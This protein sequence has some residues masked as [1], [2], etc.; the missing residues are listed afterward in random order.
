MRGVDRTL[1]IK[2]LN[3]GILV[4]QIY[5]DDIVFGSISSYHVQEFV[6]QMKNDFEMSM[7][8][9]LTYFLGL[10][11][12]QMENRIFV[13]QSNDTNSSL[14]GYSDANWPENVD[15]RKRVTRGCFILE[16]T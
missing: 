4:V 12:K 11:V 1:F 14:G 10:Q 2:Q 7:V 3:I 9:E 16:I 5:V 8:R 15:D 6:S 13:N